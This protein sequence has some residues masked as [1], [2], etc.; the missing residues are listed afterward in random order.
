MSLLACGKNGYYNFLK[1]CYSILEIYDVE[2]AE[3]ITSFEDIDVNPELYLEILTFS[4]D[5][6]L[7][8]CLYNTYH[9]SVILIFDVNSNR[10]LHKFEF[11]ERVRII[12]FN[13]NKELL[14]YSYGNDIKIWDLS[15]GTCSKTF[16]DEDGLRTLTYSKS[17]RTILSSSFN[18]GVKLRD[19]ITCELLLH[20]EDL[21]INYTE[22]NHDEK[23]IISSFEDGRLKIWDIETNTCVYEIKTKFNRSLHKIYSFVFRDNLIVLGSKEKKLKVWNTDSIHDTLVMKDD[24][25]VYDVVTNESFD[26]PLDISEYTSFCFSNPV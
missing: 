4:F 11:N 13:H 1:L 3:L 2:T 25:E 26:L 12:S 10:C 21:T 9:Y 18:H 14:S 22:F 15:T 17:G 20:I 8:A 23:L 7:L 24:T 5:N 19:A 16:E 6:S